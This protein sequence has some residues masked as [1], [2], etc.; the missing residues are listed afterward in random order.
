MYRGGLQLPI[1]AHDFSVHLVSATPGEGSAIVD[2]LGRVLMQSSAY[3]KILSR[4]LNLDRSLLHIDGNNRHWPAIKTRYGAGVEIDVASPEAV[5]ALISHLPDV[6]AAEIMKEFG[7][8]TRT[9]YFLRANREREEALRRARPAAES[10]TGL[11]SGGLG[12][13]MAVMGI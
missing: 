6:T 8:E 9:A 11:D 4:V 7:L 10:D 12:E 13:E 1:W 2:P 5:F 3:Q